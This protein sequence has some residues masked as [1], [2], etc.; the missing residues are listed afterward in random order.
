M[1]NPAF[2]SE[3]EQR[4]LQ[5]AIEEEA[6][7]VAEREE[8]RRRVE[9]STRRRL[10][11]LKPKA[12][13]SSL[14]IV[15][16]ATLARMRRE[17]GGAEIT[18]LVVL[19]EQGRMFRPE[20]PFENASPIIPFVFARRLGIDT[21]YVK[22]ECELIQLVYGPRPVIPV[23][24][25]PVIETRL[26]DVMTVGVDPSADGDLSYI[27][28]KEARRLRDEHG[29][30]DDLLGYL[31]K[32][33]A[34]MVK[35]D[36][37]N[38]HGRGR[39]FFDL[40]I[41]PPAQ[42]PAIRAINIVKDGRTRAAAV[43]IILPEKASEFFAEQ[44]F[45]FFIKHMAFVVFGEADKETPYEKLDADFKWIYTWAVHN[46]RRQDSGNSEV[47]L[48]LG[49]RDNEPGIR[50]LLIKQRQELER[51]HEAYNKSLKKEGEGDGEL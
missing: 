12:D 51:A 15:S 5:K 1:A 37:G 29:L 3:K 20:T 46:L 43:R 21:A 40:A 16:E 50:R 45:V 22:E 10:D 9:E 18:G 28:G 19:S 4:A 47:L 17:I 36:Q 31:R 38:K 32:L 41:L 7:E 39:H 34:H 48:L 13:P 44:I 14:G 42:E 49:K 33:A 25:I 2:W 11:E 23:E 30:S 35:T 27:N 24:S 8:A 26:K 6:L